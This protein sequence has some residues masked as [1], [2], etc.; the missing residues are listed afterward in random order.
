MTALDELG[1]LGPLAVEGL[2]G[3]NL[4]AA[5]STSVHGPSVTGERSRSFDVR[6]FGL[7][8]STTK[9][10]PNASSRSNSSLKSKPGA[11]YSSTRSR[12]TTHPRLAPVVTK[13]RTNTSS[14]STTTTTTRTTTRRS[15]PLSAPITPRHQV[16]AAPV[17]HYYDPFYSPDETDW[18][19]YPTNHDGSLH[20]HHFSRFS[21]S[22]NDTTSTTDYYTDSPTPSPPRSPTAPISPRWDSLS[23]NSAAICSHSH[24]AHTP[25]IASTLASSPPVPTTP[26][27]K[28]FNIAVASLATEL[29]DDSPRPVPVLSPVRRANMMAAHESR[30]VGADGLPVGNFS[31]PRPP[32]IKHTSPDSVRMR[33]GTSNTSQ[34]DSSYLDQLGQPNQYLR[35][36]DRGQ[37]ISSN[38]SASTFV[39]LPVRPP[40]DLHYPDSVR[41]RS[42]HPHPPFARHPLGYGRAES[43]G[44]P[45]TR[46]MIP[47]MASMPSDEL[48]SSYR[49]QLSSSTAPG[50]LRTERSSVL[51]KSS[52]ITSI[53]MPVDE[54]FSVDDVMDIYEEGFRDDSPERPDGHDEQDEQDDDSRPPTAKSERNRRRTALLE[55]FSDSLPMRRGNAP[56]GAENGAAAYEEDEDEHDTD[57]A[58]QA[59]STDGLAASRVSVTEST[60]HSEEREK[61][62]SKHD[63]GKLVDDVEGD[64]FP[65]RSRQTPAPRT[66]IENTDVTRDRYGFRKENQYVTQEQY[67]AWNTSYSDY[68]DRRRR[69]WQAF[70][71][72]SGL[73]T[74]DPT[75]FPQRS[76]KT[77]RFVRKGIPPEWRGAAWFYY[78]GGPA[79]LSKHGGIYNQLLAQKAKDIDTEAIERDLHRT[80]PDNIKFRAANASSIP[81]TEYH[82]PGSTATDADGNPV[83]R[84]ESEMISS[85]RRVLHAFSI[86]NPRIGYCQSLNF[87]AGLLLLFTETEEH[88]FWLLN[89]ITRVYLPGT[90]ETSLEGA[91]VDLGVLMTSVQET[92]PNVWAKIGGELD[93][94]DTVKPKSRR[95]RR[96]PTIPTR[97]PPVTLC[98]TAWFMSCFIGTLP[99]ETTLRVWDVFFYEGSK[100]LFRIALTIFKLGENEIKSVGDPMEIFQVVQAMPRRLLNANTLMEACF[101]RRNGFGHISQ[102]TIEE[103]RLERRKNVKLEKE[104]IA[105]GLTEDSADLKHKN[106]LFGKKKP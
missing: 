93:G 79:I 62:D 92:M 106:P 23:Y 82:E 30:P 100:T 37:S 35:A 12:S 96:N 66:S 10:G 65:T 68:M 44:H 87:L 76:A 8:A 9:S 95:H 69:K 52:S 77:K 105:T 67:D 19:A 39:S 33:S 54:A 103:R 32:S 80:F 55:A 73:I 84:D 61:N 91:N 36:R 2:P 88:A 7:Y 70:M 20:H 14:S 17:A 83:R 86:Y 56:N 22:T 57:P 63:S 99:I 18:H 98:M 50:T 90:H 74:D 81:N 28:H 47:R 46:E 3:S 24:H 38:Q 27:R 43:T 29:S 13:T 59:H 26:T 40:P 1:S 42:R 64:D 78:A 60:D 72:E 11:P 5:T 41:G 21:S 101:R 31:R 89:I 45:F 85:L 16:A 71:K 51:T 6:E 104:R 58:A 94:T 15:P 53:S 48:R 97:L 4:Q 34:A 75:R 25:V 49:S 102:E